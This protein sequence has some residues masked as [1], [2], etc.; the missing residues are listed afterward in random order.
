MK[1]WDADL[2]GDKLKQTEIA[3]CKDP[4]PVS[5][6]ESP[7][8]ALEIEINRSAP[9]FPKC[10]SSLDNPIPIFS[11]VALSYGGQHKWVRYTLAPNA[12][13]NV[14]AFSQ[15]IPTH[16][17]PKQLTGDQGRK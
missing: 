2:R 4:S 13:K 15:D 6:A 12:K 10:T 3:A 7:D 14:G 8:N 11:D 16:H 5:C 17:L 9:I 1:K